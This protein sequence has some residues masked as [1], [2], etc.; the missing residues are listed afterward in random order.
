MMFFNVLNIALAEEGL[1]SNYID[2]CGVYKVEGK[3]RFREFK[4]KHTYLYALI[5]HEKM[6]NEIKIFLKFKDLKLQSS[7]N[8]FLD[9]PVTTKIQIYKVTGYG[10]MFAEILEQPKIAVPSI[11]VNPPFL[12]VSTGKCLPE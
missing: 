10:T 12:K 6:V 7:S 11:T 9:L 2:G 3:M 1:Q 4:D 8:I 5:V